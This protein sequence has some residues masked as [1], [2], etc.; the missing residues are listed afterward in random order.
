MT[1]QEKTESFK[2][3]SLKIGDII[4]VQGLESSNKQSW[5]SSTKVVDIVD[6]IPYI[7]RHNKISKVTEEW[8]KNTIYIGVDP[9]KN[10]YE[11]IQSINFS[12]ESI[13][14]QLYKDD[15]YDIKGS[16]IKS[17]N[18]NPFVFVKGQKQYYQ[19]PLVWNLMDKQLL[20]ESI[21]NGV[22]CGKILV[23]NRGW[24]ELEELQKEGHELSWK[25]VVDGKQRLSAI[26]EFIDGGFC[27]IEGNY[28]YDLS[29][30]AQRRLTSHQLFSYS[31]LPEDTPDNEILKQFLKL[32][33]AGVPQSK[34]HLEFIKS[35]T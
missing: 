12:L 23:R 26:K 32:N 20:I 9:F 5:H 4:Y 24:K 35:L 31:E 25:D 14:Y 17:S 30:V 8:S 34:E 7:L 1:K 18:L 3:E 21:Y 2:S 28:Y 11:K 10:A 13:I 27:D 19:R 22:D 29:D 15:K 6:N 33:F 16:L